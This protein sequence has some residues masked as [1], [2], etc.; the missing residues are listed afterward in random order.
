M[1]KI[2]PSH[3]RGKIKGESL[4]EGPINKEKERGTNIPKGF[5]P[6]SD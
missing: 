3:W 6:D 5:R 1:E 4:S 2:E